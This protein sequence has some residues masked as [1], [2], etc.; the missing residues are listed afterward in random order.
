VTAATHR[1]QA[2]VLG[3]GNWGTTIAHLLAKNGHAVQLYTRNAPQR[4]EI[5]QHRTNRRAMP[6]LELAPGISAV[7]DVDLALEN[8]ELVFFVVPSQSFRDACRTAAD[9]L[10]PDH[11]VVHA[12]KG[13]E[14]RTHL[15]MSEI[16]L[17]ETCVRQ[18]GVLAGPN[19]AAEIARG[20]PAGTVVASSFPHVVERARAALSSPE[21]RV[22]AA[23]DVLG[24]ELCGAL[25]N[26]VAIAAGIADE[27]RVGQNAKA[28]LVTRGMAELTRLA[29]AMGAEATTMTGLAGIGDLM[30]TC[31]S[32]LSR[33]HR[34]GVALARGEKLDDIV[35]RLG[36]VAEGVYAS[37][38]ARALAELHH[39]DMPLFDRVERVLSS[40]LS[41]ADALA[42][43]MSLPAGRDVPRLST[44]PPW[45]A[46]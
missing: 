23:A 37:S 14:M 30:V 38:S 44:E 39:L 16:L 8:A 6:G 19:I 13:L 43:L 31:E 4:D 36:M 18:L 25:K 34:V 27:M 42:E 29:F 40:E 45:R 24:V 2:A 11:L 33:N 1:T 15:R 10:R 41:P 26:V 9:A 7:T 46:R 28:F 3:A 21:L 5:N 20:L 32:S 17:Q 22:F 12:T 35:E